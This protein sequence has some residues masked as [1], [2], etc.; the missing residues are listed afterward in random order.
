MHNKYAT[1]PSGG[2]VSIQTLCSKKSRGEPIA[3][4]T[5]YDFPT[6]VALDRSGID[7][8]LVGDSLGPSSLSPCNNSA[9]AQRHKTEA[10]SHCDRDED[11]PSKLCLKQSRAS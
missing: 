3:F 2:K 9:S 5:A 6:A 1:A 10:R 7:G 8:I 4:L 11:I